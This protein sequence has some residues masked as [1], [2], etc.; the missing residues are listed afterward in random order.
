MCLKMY[1]R[2]NLFHCSGLE[3]LNVAAKTVGL[4]QIVTAYIEEN[5]WLSFLSEEQ[6]AVLGS[7]SLSP[8]FSIKY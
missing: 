5:D 8:L 3:N 7:K 4:V 6:G 1:V 2:K